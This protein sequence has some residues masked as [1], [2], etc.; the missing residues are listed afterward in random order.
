MQKP[1]RLQVG[2]T[3]AVVS[4]SWGGPS[5][6]PHVLDLGLRVL[7]EEL[8]LRIVEFPT[9]R[10]DAP[11]LLRNPQARANDI[12][13]AFADP[14]V[15]AV[16]ASIGGDDSIRILPYLDVPTILANPKILMGYSDTATLLTYLNQ[17]GLVTFNGPSVMAGFAQARHLPESF[18]QN[19]R[20]LL[21]EP[22]PTYTY[23]PYPAWTNHYPDWNTPGYNGETDSLI[24]NTEGWRWL[25]GAGGVQGLLFGGCLE[26]LDF[27]K[28]TRFWPQPDSSFWDGCI[29]FLETSEDKP[30][31]NQ[32]KWSLRNYGAQ[33]VFDKAAG[34][35][36]GRARDYTPGEKEKLYKTV[37]QV[38]VD[39]FG[40]T[41][42]PIVANLDFGHTDPQFILPLG[43]LAEIN[44]DAH[45]FHLLEPAVI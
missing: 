31:I 4:P 19:V 43:V 11:W 13:R 22:T 44:C 40:A 23:T 28:G 21:F 37:V 34:L 20:S 12:N 18:L 24:L 32:V 35:L 36:L 27:L 45:T 1:K 10:A 6:F 39:E 2:D 14:N 26:V 17:Q 5:K 8:G 9:L 15:N 16:F 42:L 29:L 7:R 25:Q 30:S 3:V 33:S 41:N 38:V